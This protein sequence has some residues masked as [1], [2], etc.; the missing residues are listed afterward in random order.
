MVDFHGDD[1]FVWE[2]QKE[3]ESIPQFLKR[4]NVSFA[5]FDLLFITTILNEF[6]AFYQVVEA[7]KTLV[8]IH[9]AHSFL[10]PEGYL[11]YDQSLND[12]LRRLKLSFQRAHFYKKKI[13]E[14]AAG[15][16]FPTD[17]ILNY[18]KQQFSFPKHLSLISLPF[19]YMKE[20][21][22]GVN[23]QITTITIPG[24][25]SSEV[26][27]Y[28]LVLKAFLELENKLEEKIRL[29]LLGRSD[30][31]DVACFDS[32]FK[33]NKEKI[34]LITFDEFIPHEVYERWLLKTDFLILPLNEFGRN[35]IYREHLGYSKISGSINDMIRYGIPTLI[36]ASYP[37]EETLEELV[38]VVFMKSELAEKL[39]SW[40]QSKT[41]LE[42]KKSRKR[43]LDDFGLEKRRTSFLEKISSF[44]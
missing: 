14:A 17:R 16:A 39:E 9:N 30:K 33:L 12:R 40:I 7:N 26:R 35:Y 20:L 44:F 18:V 8:L 38:E 31:T 29:V 41:F 24:T 10:D 19:V 34:E 28:E 23:D 32:F 21:K 13:V 5:S 27:N 11:I 22:E 3:E 37:L 1:H 36:P 42:K 2:V 6:K 4:Q 43:L 15:L 25:V